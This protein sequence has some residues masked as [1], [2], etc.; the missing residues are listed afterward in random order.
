M[1]TTV[2]TQFPNRFQQE[3]L[4]LLERLIEVDS[5]GFYLVG[6]DMRH[7]GVVLHNIAPQAGRDYSQR[8]QFSDPL[9]PRHFRHSEVRLVNIDEVIGEP[10]LLAS[11][12]YQS[13]MAPMGHRH[14]TDMFFRRDG[15]IVAI[16]TLLR[17]PESGP[18]TTTELEMLRSLQPFLEY[19]LNTT[20]MPARYRQR[21]SIQE[22]YHLTAR[23][24]DVVE[25]VVSGASNKHIARDLSLG[26]ATV[27]THLQHIFHKMEVTSRTALSA[28]VLRELG[29]DN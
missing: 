26:L 11:D 4:N 17:S 18:F 3:S 2:D 24:L 21:D 5:S 15:D 28:R 16:M 22:R 9:H 12:Y 19:A 10:E 6:P 1:I 29:A 27:K 14:V 7:S 23:E 13:F 20:Y 25:R 8:Y